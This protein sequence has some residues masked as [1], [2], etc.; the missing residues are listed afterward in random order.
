MALVDVIIPVYKPGKEFFALLDLL[1]RQTLSVHEIIIINT[2]QTHWDA[3]KEKY[4]QEQKYENVSVFH[5]SKK[6]FDHGKT[7]REAVEKSRGDIF[8]MMT[9]DAMP[10]DEYLL[11]RLTEPILKEQAQVSYARQ[12]PRADAGL[13]ERYTRNFNYPQESCIKSQ[14]D[15]DTM[16]IKTFFCSNVC[17]AYNR[18]VYDKL[19]GFVE[20][21]IFNEDMI[22]AGNLVL[23]GYR[24]AYVSKACVVHSHQYTNKQQ[25]HR[26]FD[27]GVSQADHPEI[28]EIAKS[29]SEG[30]KLV[31]RTASYLLSQGQGMQIIPM[32]ITSAYKYMGYRLGKNYKKLSKKRV[33]KYTMN[34]EYFRKKDM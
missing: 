33:L 15:I 6:E 5:I 1:N 7:R 31:Q 28:F 20:S 9:Q 4:L 14:K 23:Q 19:G 11:E 24:I 3:A 17:A 10:R 12:L 27:V 8:V 26:N 25:F 34:K 21:A 18:A 30:I 32:V 13:V 22:Y 2:E 29:E 16:G